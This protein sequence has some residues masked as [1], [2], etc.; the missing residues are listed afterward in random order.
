MEFTNVALSD[1]GPE[2]NTMYNQKMVREFDP[3]HEVQN[4]S[5]ALS[6][7]MAK[8]YQNK[9]GSG[10]TKVIHNAR[11][12]S[13]AKRDKNVQKYT[14][15]H[16][17]RH[18]DS[19]GLTQIT[20]QGDVSTSGQQMRG[21]DMGSDIVDRNFYSAAQSQIGSGL[22]SIPD[23]NGGYGYDYIRHYVQK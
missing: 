9:R 2:Y 19:S 6:S 15:S 17:M 16:N 11:M 21:I 13:I 20:N 3:I 12:K 1:I 4:E 22:S 5:S 14:S 18:I 23:T 7:T 8:R 10:V